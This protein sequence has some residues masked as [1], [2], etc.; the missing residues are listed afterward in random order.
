MQHGCMEYLDAYVKRKNLDK[1]T[2]IHP[3]TNKNKKIDEVNLCKYSIFNENSF[4]YS[5]VNP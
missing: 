3:K 1:E 4:F 5:N 2:E